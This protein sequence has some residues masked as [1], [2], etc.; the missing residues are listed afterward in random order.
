MVESCGPCCRLFG[1]PP[2]PV[3]FIIV[4]GLPHTRAYKRILS[5][6]KYPDEVVSKKYSRPQDDYPSLVEG[7]IV[8][9]DSRNENLSRTSRIVSHA[10][11]TCRGFRVMKYEGCRQS[12]ISNLETLKEEIYDQLK[13]QSKMRAE[14]QCKT[15]PTWIVFNQSTCMEREFLNIFLQNHRSESVSYSFT[16]LCILGDEEAV[17]NNCLSANVTSDE[18]NLLCTQYQ[19]Q[20]EDFFTLLESSHILQERTK[21]IQQNELSTD[22][23]IQRTL[24]QLPSEVTKPD[25]ATILSWKYMKNLFMPSRRIASEIR[26]QP[27]VSEQR[28]TSHLE[29]LQNELQQGTS[30]EDSVYRIIDLVLFGFNSMTQSNRNIC[31]RVLILGSNS[32]SRQWQPNSIASTL[33][34]YALELLDKRDDTKSSLIFNLVRVICILGSYSFDFHKLID[35]ASKI[36]TLSLSL[37]SR[38]DYVL[39]LVGLKL[40]ATILKSDRLKNKYAIAYLKHDENAVKTIM[41]AVEWLLSPY[42]TLKDLWDKRESNDEQATLEQ[43]CLK[44]ACILVDRWYL[45]CITLLLNSPEVRHCFQIEVQHANR[46]IEAIDILVDQRLSHQR[47]KGKPYSLLLACDLCTVLSPLL[48]R[49]LPE[50]SSFLTSDSRLL[51]SLPQIIQSTLSI[52]EEYINSAVHFYTLLIQSIRKDVT[53]GSV[54]R[55]EKE[56]V[57][58]AEELQ[59]SSVASTTETIASVDESST[60]IDLERDLITFYFELNRKYHTHQPRVETMNLNQAEMLLRDEWEKATRQELQCENDRLSKE[61]NSKAEVIRKLEDELERTKKDRDQYR[62]EYNELLKNMAQPVNSTAPNTLIS[63]TSGATVAIQPSN[64][65]ADDD[66]LEKLHPREISVEDAKRFIQAIYQRRVTFKDKEMRQSIC[67]SLR[68]LGSDLYTS[69]IHFLYELIQ[70]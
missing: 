51:K 56:T 17:L 57:R 58:S 29:S 41:D 25:D 54:L 43:Q 49:G 68:Q 52:Q 64:E 27:D 50:V 69:S 16:V 67:G 4:T 23:Q 15:R 13:W 10:N 45:R 35:G 3:N 32:P 39:V 6:L 44:H 53:L 46:L 26:I 60:T 30:V 48:Q 36:F 9:F 42:G 59:S 18:Y 22:E 2:E 11:N 70:V 14:A 24:Y 38:R 20:V 63:R 21:L 5:L 65:I 66:R 62:M 55:T 31:Q 33:I 47:F 37:I 19:K 12:S 40:C 7:S 1:Q 34:R 8:L 28:L 61:N